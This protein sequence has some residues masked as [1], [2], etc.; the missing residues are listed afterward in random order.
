MFLSI[1]LYL[2][3]DDIYFRQTCSAHQTDIVCV[4]LFGKTVLMELSHGGHT[5]A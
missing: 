2:Y 3:V 5:L 1:S 4:V